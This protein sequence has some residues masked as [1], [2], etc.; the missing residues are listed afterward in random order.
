MRLSFLAEWKGFDAFAL[1]Y[2]SLAVCTFILITFSWQE[3]HSILQPQRVRLPKKCSAPCC[4]QHFVPVL[5]SATSSLED[6][7]TRPCRNS[8]G[9]VNGAVQAR[10]PAEHRKTCEEIITSGA[11]SSACHEL[12]LAL[13]ERATR[14]RSY[15]VCTSTSSTCLRHLCAYYI[16]R[17]A[18]FA[19][20]SYKNWTKIS[21][22]ELNKT[23]EV[24]SENAHVRFFLGS[25]KAFRDRETDAVLLNALKVSMEI[26]KGQ[27]LHNTEVYA[28]GYLTCSAAAM[29]A[30]PIDEDI[31]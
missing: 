4:R 22:H 26:L 7:R 23:I 16:N 1:K 24:L 18:G 3:L 9:F 8:W 28:L 13:S 6:M 31:Y 11:D 17:E 25:M 14:C 19:R 10:F 5:P 27:N 12:P 21:A 20:N 29:A 30:I 15:G 2:A